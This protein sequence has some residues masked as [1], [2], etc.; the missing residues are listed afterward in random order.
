MK[1]RILS[2]AAQDLTKSIDYYESQSDGLG[3]DFLDEYEKTISRICRFPEAWL[4]VTSHLRRCL[5][6][7][8]PYAIFYT[9][10][11]DEIVITAVADLRMDPDNI[12]EVILR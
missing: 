5:M 6:R 11:E 7:R 4:L 9:V 2:A 10:M 1:L 12:R 8:F 3:Y